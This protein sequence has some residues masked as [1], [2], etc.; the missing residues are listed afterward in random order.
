MEEG[1]PIPADY[2]DKMSEP[3]DLN[4]LL[5]QGV[6]LSSGANQPQPLIFANFA[7][8]QTLRYNLNVSTGAQRSY[9]VRM[10]GTPIK[11]RATAAPAR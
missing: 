7:L 10:Q 2:R 11:Y 8:N 5:I 3:W 6:V 1:V 4:L 9:R